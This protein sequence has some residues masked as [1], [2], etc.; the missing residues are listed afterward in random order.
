MKTSPTIRVRF[1]PSPTGFLHIG[2]LRTALYNWLFARKH[3][4]EFI[5]R[6]EDTDRE[7]IVPGALENIQEALRWYGLKW[8]EGPVMQ[9]ERLE[10]YKA[11][12][13]TLVKQEGAYDCFCTKERLERVRKAQELAKQPPRYDGH[14]RN[15]SK[16][17]VTKRLQA[18]EPHVIRLKIPDEGSTVFQDIIHGSVSFE[19]KN[20]DDQVLLKSD[21]FP[22]YH[23][24]NVVDDHDM[25]ISHV[26]RGDEWLPSTPK[27]VLLYE[28]FGW[29]L[30]EFAHLPIILGKDRSKLSKRH[31][32]K[33]AL[34]Y[35]DAG[36]LPQAVLNFISLLGWNPGT[37]QEIFHAGELIEAFDLAKVNKAGAVFDSDKLDWMNGMYIRTM[38][39]KELAKALMPFVK[40]LHATEK[41]L[42]RIAPLFQER[43]KTLAEFKNYAIFF[44]LDSLD[45]DPK[46][47][48]PKKGTQQETVRVLSDVKEFLPTLPKSVFRHNQLKQKFEH[49]VQEKQ[50]TNMAV[51]WPL[52]VALTGLA[53]S[54]GVFEVMEALGPERSMKRVGEAIQ[55]L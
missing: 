3:K 1:A 29:R 14:C 41:D 19:N 42:E 55:K 35:R 7:R 44:F 26:I 49:F 30:P 54:P 23:L 32:A 8:N 21:G 16:D 48:I 9:S 38:K 25:G 11:H 43:L 45:Y 37:E 50:Y 5:L 12:A 15:L 46:L 27:H 4:G 34:E 20:L 6:I 13:A 17:E 53:A 39:P 31:G 24:A 28:A 52:R 18:G 47:L 51:L 33:P 10:K 40:D 2:G 36:Y 22:T